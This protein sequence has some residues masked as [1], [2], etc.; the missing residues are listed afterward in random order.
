VCVFITARPITKLFAGGGNFIQ[1]DFVIQSKSPPG[2]VFSRGKIAVHFTV[3]GC[4][5]AYLIFMRILSNEMM[6]FSSRLRSL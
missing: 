5:T 1:G 2:K 4:L 6:E 3:N